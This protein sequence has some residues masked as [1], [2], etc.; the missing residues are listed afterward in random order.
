MKSLLLLT[1]LGVVGYFVYQK[2][3]APAEAEPEAKATLAAPTPVQ[4]DRIRSRVRRMY[5]EWKARSLATQKVQQSA[6]RADIAVLLTEIR[7]ILGD[8][9]GVHSP[10]A[11]EKAISHWL[12]VAESEK[13]YVYQRLLEEA[14]KDGQRGG[15]DKSLWA[16]L[17]PQAAAE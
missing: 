14:N 8:D 15:H 10:E 6:R 16:P 9:N 11:L 17:Q 2:R 3:L 12:P 5:E 1:C 13:S 7:K 4:N